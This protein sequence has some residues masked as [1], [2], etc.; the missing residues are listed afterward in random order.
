MFLFLVRVACKLRLASYGSKLASQSLS[1]P[2][3]STY[4]TTALLLEMSFSRLELQDM[5]GKLWLPTCI[6]VSSIH[7]LCILSRIS[8]KLDRS[9]MDVLHIQ[10]LLYYHSRSLIQHCVYTAS[11]YI[12]RYLCATPHDNKTNI[13]YDYLHTYQRRL[14]CQ[15]CIVL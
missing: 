2:I 13:A 3:R 11:P 8:W 12:H 7:H 4:G 6:A 5:A 10:W 9:Y 15:Q 1:N 14:Y